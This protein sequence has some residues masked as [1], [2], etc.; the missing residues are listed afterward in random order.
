MRDIGFRAWNVEEKIMISS[1]DFAFETYLPL[2]ELFQDIKFRFMQ[3][4]GIKDKNGKDIYEGDIIRHYNR[5]QF[6]DAYEVAVVIY[7][8]QRASF[9]KKNLG[10]DKTFAI[11]KG[12]HYEVIG[13]IYENPELLQQREIKFRA[14]DKQEEKMIYNVENI[15]SGSF[16]L[17]DIQSF[18]QLISSPFYDLMQ[19]T[20]L[21]DKNGKDIYDGDI[22]KRKEY[23][24]AN[25]YKEVLRP[26]KYS[27]ESVWMVGSSILSQI[28]TDCEV[29]GNIYEINKLPKQ[30]N[31]NLKG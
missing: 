12:C 21:K 18:G 2:C 5:P 11:G 8:D 3:Y 31:I 27:H 19:Y 28:Y 30:I 20:G 26:V 29:V 4:I 9:R 24:F 25:Q 10:E 16:Q 13:N 22:V 7:E 14:W 23:I 1:N 17:K 15:G 6:P